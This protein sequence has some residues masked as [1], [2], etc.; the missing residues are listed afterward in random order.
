MTGTDY[1]SERLKKLREKQGLTQQ[2]VADALEVNRQTVYR[3]EAGRLASYKLLCAFAV[4]YQVQVSSLLLP[5][6]ISK[7]TPIFSSAT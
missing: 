4:F 6:P 5:R 7:K 2:E 1:N 3:A